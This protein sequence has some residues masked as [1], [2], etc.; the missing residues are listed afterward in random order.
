MKPLL[1]FLVFLTA[2]Y[3]IDGYFFNGRYLG[4]LKQ[5]AAAILGI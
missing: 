3:C 1:S 4:A 5:M 2:I